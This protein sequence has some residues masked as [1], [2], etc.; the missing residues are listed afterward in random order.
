MTA[1]PE[2]REGPPTASEGFLGRWLRLK[3]AARGAAGAVTGAPHRPEPGSAVSDGPPPRPGPAQPPAQPPDHGPRRAGGTAGP[4]RPAAPAPPPAQAEA[5][6]LPPLESLDAQSDFRPFLAPEVD[7]ALRRQAL[8]K[9]FH[10]PERNVRDG[11]TDYWEDYTHFEPLGDL[12]PHEVR[13]ALER[14][15]RRLTEAAGDTAPGDQASAQAHTAPG[16]SAARAPHRPE[17]QPSPGEAQ[18]GEPGQPE[19]SGQTGD[20]SIDL[21][22][23]PDPA[24]RVDAGS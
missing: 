24:P 20:D 8:R 22:G 19:P 3:Q 23:A 12:V 16:A 4:D 11:L 10:L 18:G 1:R 17:P 9:L 13:A 14:E 15:A 2:R 5:V 21:A 7:P 6:E